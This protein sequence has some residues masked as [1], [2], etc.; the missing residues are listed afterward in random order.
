[1]NV[2]F[3]HWGVESIKPG[4]SPISDCQM[5][6]TENGPEIR[7]WNAATL[8]A[9]PTDAD[10]AAAGAAHK[11]TVDAAKADD[12]SKRTQIRNVLAALDAGTATQAQVQKVL[13]FLVRR[14]L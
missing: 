5:Q 8:G 7:L 11:A 9:R 12:E 1:M 2:N 4:Y 6:A 10:L 3:L 14:M 13:A